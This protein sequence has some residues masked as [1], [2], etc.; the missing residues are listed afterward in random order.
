M[1][2]RGVS[3]AG[4]RAGRGPPVLVTRGPPQPLAQWVRAPEEGQQA[5]PQLAV[6]VAQAHVL[7]HAWGGGRTAWEQRGRGSLAGMRA[8]LAGSAA[9]PP[10]SL[11]RRTRGVQRVL[12][13]LQQWA[14]GHRARAAAAAAAREPA[15]ELQQAGRR[16]TRSERAVGA[17]R[18][19]RERGAQQR[20]H[21][22]AAGRRHCA[23]VPMGGCLRLAHACA[24]RRG[25]ARRVGARPL[26]WP[27]LAASAGGGARARARA[28]G[29]LAGAQR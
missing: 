4:R 8:R 18:G 27:G 20:A 10:Q 12:A 3:W 22:A 16:T 9:L 17:A 19:A 6:L 14:L 7:L 25:G 5:A 1:G 23:P 26:V 29:A 15:G 11:P 28:I 24:A 2:C 13:D 21:A